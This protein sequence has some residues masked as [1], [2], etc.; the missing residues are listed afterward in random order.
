MAVKYNVVRTTNGMVFA[1]EFR[2]YYS[3]T[4]SCL[5]IMVQVDTISLPAGIPC[6]EDCQ[7]KTW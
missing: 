1:Q 7:L 6:K 3:D 5:S 2:N 4:N